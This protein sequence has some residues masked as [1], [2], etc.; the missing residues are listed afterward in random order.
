MK[1]NYHKARKK[2]EAI[3][4]SQKDRIN[5]KKWAEILNVST[6]YL[7]Q[8]LSGKRISYS[9]LFEIIEILG[10]DLCETFEIYDKKTLKI[11]SYLTEM[12]NEELDLL[13]KEI[14]EKQT[15]SN[16]HPKK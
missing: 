3:V 9:Y 12:S 2:I 6:G 4:K 10:L 11:I 13:L 7:S 15:S 5:Q 14:S 16:T 1:L 8:L